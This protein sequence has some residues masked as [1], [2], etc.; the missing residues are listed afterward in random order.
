MSDKAFAWRRW[1]EADQFL[2]A[3]YAELLSHNAWASDFVTRLQSQTGTT[4]PDWVDHVQIN[5]GRISHDVLRELGFKPR[6]GEDSSPTRRVYTHPGA[7]LPKV[8]VNP[9]TSADLPGS[10]HTK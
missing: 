9:T 3:R 2:G 4:L 7:D 10:R 8:V 1:P 6:R 5:G